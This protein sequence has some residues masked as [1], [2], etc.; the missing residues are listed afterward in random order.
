ME[1]TV[2]TC[3]QAWIAHNEQ[4]YGP[5]LRERYGDDVVDAFEKKFLGMSA[6]DYERVN[7]LEQQI[8]DQLK[9]AKQTNDPAGTSAQQVCDLHRQWL[10]AYWPR[11][12]KQ[13]HLELGKAYVTDDRFRAYYDAIAPGCAQFL[14]DALHIYCK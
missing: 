3:K 6:A 5:E 11:Y 12:D 8:K 9:E 13:A 10:E 7:S 2:T 4:Q 1:D 14:C